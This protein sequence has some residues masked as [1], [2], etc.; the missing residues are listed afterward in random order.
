[1]I[2]KK[3]ILLALVLKVLWDACLY[4][5]TPPSFIIK[6]VIMRYFKLMGYL[7]EAFLQGGIGVNVK[8]EVV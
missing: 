1:M 5:E 8:K 7:K 2:F 4:Y 6:A 3:I